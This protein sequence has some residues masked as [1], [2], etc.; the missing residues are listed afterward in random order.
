MNE[1]GN[2]IKFRGE[3]NVKVGDHKDTH[4]DHLLLYAFVLMENQR[5]VQWYHSHSPSSV[6]L[7]THHRVGGK[8][9]GHSIDGFLGVVGR[10]V[11]ALC[12]LV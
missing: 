5:A 3:N 4:H 9:R 2:S 7:Q 6:H 12:S 1:Y 10:G 8:D 11:S